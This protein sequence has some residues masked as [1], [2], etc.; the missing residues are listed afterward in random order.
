[1]SDISLNIFMQRSYMVRLSHL[2]T[3]GCGFESTKILMSDIGMDSVADM[4]TLPSDIGM[5]VSVQ[6]IFFSGIGIT[7]VD[8]S[9]VGYR[10]HSDRCRCPPILTKRLAFQGYQIESIQYD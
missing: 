6:Y 4:G 10:R 7:D 3:K 1:M 8:M 5:T 2:K 9:D